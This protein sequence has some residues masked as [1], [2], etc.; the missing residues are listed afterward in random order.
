MSSTALPL[1]PD[2]SVVDHVFAERRPPDLPAI[3]DAA[4]GEVLTYGELTA[5]I[6]LVAG[7]LQRRGLG[8]G[9]VVAILGLNSGQFAV[10]LYASLRTGATVTLVNSLGSEAEIGGQLAHSRASLLFADAACLP[11]VP[12]GTPVVGLDRPAVP[13]GPTVRS[14][15][16]LGHRATAVRIDP[17]NDVALLP[18]SSGTSGASKAVMLTHRNLVANMCQNDG[19]MTGLTA[20]SRVLAVP[21][22]FHIYG[23]QIVLNLSLRA[24]ARVVTL[25]RF[26]FTAFLE[27]IAEHRTDRV[28]VSP[29]VLVML[30]KSPLVDSYDL[31]AVR[32]LFSGA[33][34]LD[35]DLAGKVA[36]RLGCRIRQ[37]Y[38]MT[39]LSP[40]SHATPDHR[41]DLPV[42][43]VGL[44][45]PHMSWRVV[46][47]AT[48]LDV[49]PGQVGELWCR[50]PNVMKGYLRDP[51]ATA[52]TIDAAGYLHTGDLVTYDDDGVFTVVDRLKELIKYKGHQVPPAELEAVLVR[53][54]DIADVAV[55]GRSDEVAGQIPVAFVVRRPGSEELTAESVME[56]AAV[57]AGAHKKVRA[58]R[59]VD[60]IPK[61][62]SGKILRRLLPE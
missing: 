36:S 59:F 12:G 57:H 23:A 34:P 2:H 9:D 39:E 52:A 48:G 35:E 19:F 38:G 5:L 60:R 31:S 62:G 40:T 20:D 56:F 46:D 37:G 14:L 7:A 3:V 11:R 1:I 15:A 10:A 22:F 18:Y 53:H 45:V 55:A 44:P 13:G 51:E 26:D 42:G 41:D 27:A 30:A 17:D 6:D 32:Y 16:D 21:P 28:C 49:L 43:S 29:P 33:A 61:S 4:T 58:V 25:P 24:G 50:G 8:V 54:P 47:P